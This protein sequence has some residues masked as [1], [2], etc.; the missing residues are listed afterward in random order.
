MPRS[1]LLLVPLLV[2]LPLACIHAPKLDAQGESIFAPVAGEPVLRV[3]TLN[4][5]HATGVPPL[6]VMVPTDTR[7][8][9]LEAI[10]TLV[11]RERPAIVA[12]QEVHRPLE[13]HQGLDHLTAI[14]EASGY[15]SGFFGS[16]LVA[17]AKGREQGTALLARSQLLAPIS[18]ALNLEPGDDKGFVR[19]T[20]RVPQFFNRE[21]DVFSVHLDPY[22][23]RKRQQQVI[24]L[25]DALRKRTH[26][27]IVMGDFN[28]RYVGPYE[29]MGRLLSLT[30]LRAHELTS[31]KAT[32]PAGWPRARLDWIL[33]TPE[34]E[35]SR[36][37]NVNAGVSDHQGVIAEV[38]L[39]QPQ[40]QMA[41]RDAPRE[42][43][44][45]ATA[46]ELALPRA[47]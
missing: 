20:L 6:S 47:P 41:M 25:A 16:H 33:L 18:Q 26:P 46:N 28:A 2:A 10:G 29:T 43:T 42:V 12:M 8:E 3:M 38:R 45:E 11:R 34:L 24:A 14:R 36:Y 19:A 21:V 31:G 44:A 4:I 1:P 5:A 13:G 37:E 39:T 35:F 15:A 7:R 40:F 17:K 23:E 30:N 9:F 32:Y 27:A 22:S